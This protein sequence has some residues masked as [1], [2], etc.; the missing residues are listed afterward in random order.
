MSGGVGVIGIVGM[1]LEF[2]IGL[3]GPHAGAG[4]RGAAGV[5]H[6]VDQ[7]AVE[8]LRDRAGDHRGQEPIDRG[9]GLGAELVERQAVDDR[10]AHALVEDPPDLCHRGAAGAAD[11]IRAVG[12]GWSAAEIRAFRRRRGGSRRGSAGRQRDP[13]ILGARG[14]R[15]ARRSGRRWQWGSMHSSLADDRAI[16]LWRRQAPQGRRIIEGVGMDALVRLNALKLPFAELMGIEFVE[17]APERVVAEMSVARRALHRPGGVAWRC[18]HGLCRHARRCRDDPQ[19]AGR[20]GHDDDREQDQLHRRRP[21]RQP[22]SPGRPPRC[23]AAGAPRCGR[24]GS[25]PPRAG[26]SRW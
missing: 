21:A 25:P 20:G 23:I 4:Q 8:A 7:P 2:D 12:A 1:E 15:D 14:R 16:R 6:I 26:S 19:P 11:R 3:V 10:E 13:V 24:P 17:A 5:A 9:R 18:D 22:R